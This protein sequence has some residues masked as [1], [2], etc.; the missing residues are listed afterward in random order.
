MTRLDTAIA[1]AQSG[2]RAAARRLL[3]G[4]WSDVGPDGDP[5]HR[6]A[7]A[8]AM[9]DVQDDPSDELWWDLH[10]LE[11]AKLLTDERVRAGGVAGSAAGFVTSL[12]L[13]LADVYCRLGEVEAA[14]EHVRLGRSPLRHLA[15]DGYRDMI[16]A[17]LAGVSDRAARRTGPP[18]LS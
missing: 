17:A 7:L 12:H 6:C 11:A 5:F 8:H 18:D 1:A 3:T 16:E 10:A 4:I 2:D 14:A 13:N 15:A 9:A